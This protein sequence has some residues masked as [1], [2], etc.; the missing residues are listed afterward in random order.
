[1]SK[2]KGRMAMISTGN[3]E[4]DAR[5]IASAELSAE[6]MDKNICPNGC[7]PMEL[8]DAHNRRCPLCNFHGWQNTPILESLDIE[9]GKPA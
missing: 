4:E 9:S 2:Y 5:Q 1:M 7:G 8:L 6:R 3:P